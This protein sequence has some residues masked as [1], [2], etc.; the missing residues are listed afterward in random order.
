MLVRLT[1]TRT[2]IIQ[3]INSPECSTNNRILKLRFALGFMG[4]SIIVS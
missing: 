1:T 3:E 2:F 4:H